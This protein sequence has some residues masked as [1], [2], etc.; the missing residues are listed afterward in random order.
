MRWLAASLVALLALVG[1][2]RGDTVSAPI[3]DANEDGGSDTSADTTHGDAAADAFDAAA[4]SGP[5]SAGEVSPDSGLADLGPFDAAFDGG[6][7]PVGKNLVPGFESLSGWASTGCTLTLIDAP[8]GKGLRVFTTAMY[9][10]V[11]RHVYGS[12][13]KGA[14]V[15]VRAWFHGNGVTGGLPPAV[16]ARFT[17]VDDAGVEVTQEIGVDA[18][19]KPA[20]VYM[21]ATEVLLADKTAFDLLISSNRSDGVSDDYYVAGVSVSVD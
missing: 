12:W 8:C 5:D 21:E 3:V 4:D 16:T 9:A 19:L 7:T 14:V 11:R 18:D 6:C 15:H 1:G 10:N 2:C 13:P 20:W 17:H